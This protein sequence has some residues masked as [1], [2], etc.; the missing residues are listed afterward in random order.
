[1]QIRQ[2][3]QARAR[4]GPFLQVDDVD[5]ESVFELSGKTFD[6]RAEILGNREQGIV[7][8]LLDQNFVAMFQQRCHREM[9]RHRGAARN[10]DDI[11]SPDATMH[12]ERI[13]QWPI[14][15]GIVAMQL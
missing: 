5:L 1:M 10:S 14:A 6:L 11:F 15:V 13:D 7:G 12:C 2:H 9:I 4:R 3:D 8:W